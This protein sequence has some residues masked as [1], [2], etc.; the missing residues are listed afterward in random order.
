MKPL[1]EEIREI[2][3]DVWKRAIIGYPPTDKLDEERTLN[4]ALSAILKAVGDRVPKKNIVEI[5]Q[6]KKHIKPLDILLEGRKEGWN[7]ALTEIKKE[8]AI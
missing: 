2:L 1:S 7:Q 5:L 6:S 4:D 3:K 8:L